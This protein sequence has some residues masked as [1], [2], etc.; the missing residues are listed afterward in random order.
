[1]AEQIVREIEVY[2]RRLLLLRT[3]AVWLAYDP[4]SDGKRRPARDVR[5]PEFVQTDV[6]LE[7]YLA[8]LLHERASPDNATI[9]WRV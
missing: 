2:G 1:M 3:G 6:E 9:R 8:D 4:G 7:R 5:I